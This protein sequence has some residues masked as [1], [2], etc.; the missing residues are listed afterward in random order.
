[1][2]SSVPQAV[3]VFL[4]IGV[5]SAQYQ[6]WDPETENPCRSYGIDFQDNGGPYFQNISSP[7]KFTFVSTFEGC[8]NDY[9]TNVIV[10][11][12]GDQLQ[13]SDTKMQPD[14]TYQMSTCP[15][16]KNSLVSGE[17]SLVILSNNGDQQPI[18]YQRDFSLIVG[19]PATS[20][21]GRHP[22]F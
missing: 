22:P 21:V 20:T 3:A 12:N 5:C 8:Q 19:E 11:P 6:T 17:W 7:E 1:M 16:T 14:D 10:D 2:R 13:C 18:A 4:A 15:Q 9:A